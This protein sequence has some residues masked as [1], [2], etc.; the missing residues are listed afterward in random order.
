[1]LLFK[2]NPLLN[3]SESTCLVTP[4]PSTNDLW[5]ARLAAPPLVMER[6]DGLL[7]KLQDGL[8]RGVDL[9]PAFDFDMA[10]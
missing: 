4:M 9:K 1:M 6:W 8:F 3:I 7:V 5:I 10:G 2:V